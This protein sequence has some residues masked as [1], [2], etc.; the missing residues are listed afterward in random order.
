[1]LDNEP[2]FR[3]VIAALEH[4]EPDRVPLVEAAVDYEIMGRFL[5]HPVVDSDIAAQVN[6]WKAAGYDYVPLTV[7][8]MSPGG[9]TKDSQIS[10]TIQNVVLRDAPERENA[11]AWNLEQRSFIHTERDLEDF[12]WAEAARLDTSKFYQIAPLLPPG[13]KVVA[14]SGKIFTLSW[15]LMGFENFAINS[16]TNQAFVQRLVEKVARIQLAGL[17]EVAGLPYVAAAWAV[18]DLCFG[19]GPILRP[20]VLRKTIF[21]WYE[22]FGAI[23]RSHGL[24][25]LFHTDG[26]V[27]DLIDDLLGLGIRALHPIDPTCMDID[28]VKL[29]V[30]QRLC[31]MGNISN[32]LLQNGTPKEV[33]ELTKRRLHTLGPGGGYCLGSGNS[34]PAWARLD[35]YRAMLAADFAYGRYPLPAALC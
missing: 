12:P 18:D 10:K 21:P 29:R 7:G 27:W 8:M 32:E 20:T 33:A 2:D 3:R 30:G 34:V 11:N 14:L 25:F 5:G 4:E 23:C 6:F 1:M 16:V 19:S 17:R 24:H 15:M 26:V 13:M 35:N 9:V 22:E 28:E 31:I